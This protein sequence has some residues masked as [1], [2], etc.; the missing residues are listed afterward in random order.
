MPNAFITGLAGPDLLPAERAFLARGVSVDAASREI[1]DLV[2][3]MRT[4][5]AR[6]NDWGRTLRVRSLQ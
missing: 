1:V 2:R 4:D 6:P 3:A 5:L